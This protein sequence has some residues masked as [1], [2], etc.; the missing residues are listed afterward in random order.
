MK[1]TDELELWWEVLCNELN[2]TD[3][4]HAGYTK[5]LMAVGMPDVI[6]TYLDDLSMYSG[7]L[8]VD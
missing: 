8:S 6:W 4:V 3:K 5:R 2:S 1:N 7:G